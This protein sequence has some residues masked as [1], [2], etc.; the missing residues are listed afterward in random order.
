V[1]KI[2]GFQDVFGGKRVLARTQGKLVSPSGVALPD[3][4]N[5]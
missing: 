3:D 1:Y 4:D 5:Q 2:A